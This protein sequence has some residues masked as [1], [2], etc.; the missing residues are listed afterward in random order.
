MS[1]SWRLPQGITDL[2]PEQSEQL[3]QLSTALLQVWK[4]WGY[5]VIHPPIVE[6]VKTGSLIHKTHNT[7][8]TIDTSDGAILEIRSDIT[9]QI[10]RI[11]A[12]NK[13]N[14]TQ[15]VSRYCYIENILCASSDD[16]YASRNAIQAG[17]E[18]YGSA[19]DLAD[20]EIIE[21]MYYSLQQSGFDQDILI[22]LGHI[23][24]FNLLSEPLGLSATKLRRL[25]DIFRHKSKQDLLDFFATDS[26]SSAQQD[27]LDLLKFNGN[28][29]ILSQANKHYAHLPKIILLIKALDDIVQSLLKRGFAVHLDL[30]ELKNQNYYTGLLFA[31]FIDGY[32][33]ALAQGG[34]YDDLNDH[35]NHTLN[36]EIRYATGFSFD[37]KFITSLFT[38]TTQQT[39]TH[40][41]WAKDEMTP[42]VVVEKRKKG[43]I[44]IRNF[45]T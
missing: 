5:Q 18:L 35:D 15:T 36:E 38:P 27:L 43:N 32:S 17:A 33:K 7:F 11:D 30:A 2:T 12:K 23:G 37:L 3:T 42:K 40:N 1:I 6:P 34:R 9:P 4:T 24:F 26:L 21:L 44:V 13:K 22:G 10:A 45:Q 25:K 20:V 28:V 29:E 31:C 8:K 14:K 16:F 39:I 19:S 41:T